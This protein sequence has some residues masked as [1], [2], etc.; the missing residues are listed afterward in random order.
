M[1]VIWIGLDGDDIVGGRRGRYVK[2]RNGER[3]PRVVLTLSAPRVP[4][5]GGLPGR[6][7][8]PARD[9]HR[10]DR[11]MKDGTPAPPPNSSAKARRRE[12]TFVA[13]GR[14]RG[15]QHCARPGRTSAR[16]SLPTGGIPTFPTRRPDSCR[17]SPTATRPWPHPR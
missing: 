13:A 6:I 10:H 12:R 15:K 14:F 3:D 5:D 2:V 7:H 1:S 17:S 11:R 8:H 9:G 16:D 4:G